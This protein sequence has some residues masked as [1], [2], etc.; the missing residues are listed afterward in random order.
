MNDYV[1]M[2]SALYLD[3]LL[4]MQSVSIDLLTLVT[5]FVLMREDQK[6]VRRG[7]IVKV[8]HKVL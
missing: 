4:M 7:K 1:E 8:P 6:E 3:K 2:R 5:C